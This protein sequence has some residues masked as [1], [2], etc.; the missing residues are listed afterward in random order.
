MSVHHCCRFYGLGYTLR[1]DASFTFTGIH[2]VGGALIT[3][4]AHHVA[5]YCRSKGLIYTVPRSILLSTIASIPGACARCQPSTTKIR[6]CYTKYIDIV[7]SSYSEVFCFNYCS[8][9]WFLD[10]TLAGFQQGWRGSGRGAGRGE[11]PPR[12]SPR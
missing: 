3:R 10:Y 1:T 7:Y 5:L 12:A 6:L 11:C 4:S 2:G 8:I 9:L